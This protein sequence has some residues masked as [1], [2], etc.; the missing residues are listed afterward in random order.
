[1]QR[2]YFNKISIVF[3]ERD[4]EL[5]Q[6]LINVS[7]KKMALI[8][9]HTLGVDAEV[10]SNGCEVSSEADHFLNARTNPPSDRNTHVYFSDYQRKG[11]KS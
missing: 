4:L 9:Q 8:S 7:N 10:S 2:F 11:S 6:N 1:M 5:V 3:R